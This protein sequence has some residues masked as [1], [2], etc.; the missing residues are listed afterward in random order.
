M[1]NPSPKLS[2]P[3]WEAIL[4]CT[5]LPDKQ[6][7]FTKACLYGQIKG[8][9]GRGVSDVQLEFTTKEEFESYIMS[10]GKN[11]CCLAF[12]K[13]S[14]DQWFLRDIKEQANWA[15]SGHVTRF[16][17]KNGL[18]GID[19]VN[20][21]TNTVPCDDPMS[22]AATIYQSMKEVQNCFRELGV[23]VL[24]TL[25]S[26]SFA[27]FRQH[28]PIPLHRDVDYN[29]YEAN[30]YYAGRL[31][32]YRTGLWEAYSYDVTA[33][34][35]SIMA[36]ND[37]PLPQSTKHSE[38]N[39]AHFSEKYPCMTHCTVH[40]PDGTYVPILP[41][42]HP[43]LG[44]IFPTGTFSGTWPSPELHKA[45]E[46]G[47]RIL[48]VHDFLYYTD[49]HPIFHDFANTIFAKREEYPWTK[50]A[51]N[52]IYGKFAQR[53]RSQAD[54]TPLSTFSGSIEDLMEYQLTDDWLVKPGGVNGYTDHTFVVISAWISCLGR[55]QLFDAMHKHQEDLCYVDT[56]SI[57]T[58]NP[59]TG[60]TIGTGMGQWKQEHAL[61][62]INF[63]G[64]KNYEMPNKR[65][66]SGVPSTAVKLQEGVYEYERRIS[67]REGIKSGKMP[68]ST[69]IRT[70]EFDTPETN[71]MEIGDGFTMPHH[72]GG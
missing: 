8:K 72:V 44:V 28:L 5:F 64:I 7:N 66:V 15:D 46:E 55:L 35:L 63:R 30:G 34:Y 41:Y 57:K 65:V 14:H 43:E 71:R 25:S 54:I 68:T 70:L 38:H 31:E 48:K 10:L 32:C 60:L 27:L 21:F 51:G 19:L 6:G 9:D 50:R 52:A 39:Y 22:H 67:Y 37:F 61:L 40:V 4:A 26:T 62:P 59:A 56:D 13:L 49:W 18:R 42:R 2:K 3:R 33:M 45:E 12:H 36:N 16:R 53:S 58:T 17:L 20:F 47:T 1:I 29:A 24:D 69:E 11:Q 23:P